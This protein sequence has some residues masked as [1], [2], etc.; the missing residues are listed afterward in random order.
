MNKEPCLCGD[1][2]CRKCFPPQADYDRLDDLA[3]ELYDRSV[4][5][6]IDAPYE[7]FFDDPTYANPEET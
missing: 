6:Q 4:Q 3:D 2:F 5:E 7:Q 1:P